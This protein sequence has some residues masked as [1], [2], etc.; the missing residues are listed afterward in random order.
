VLDTRVIGS[1]IRLFSVSE[2]R[3]MQHDAANIG[4]N[5]A[6][7]AGINDTVWQA[8]PIVAPDV[9]IAFEKA[10]REPGSPSILQCIGCFLCGREYKGGH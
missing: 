7:P 3:S 1:A 5:G 6:F 10:G 8:L 4:Q 2:E 9:P